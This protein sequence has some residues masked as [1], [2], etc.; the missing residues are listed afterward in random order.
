MSE[1]DICGKEAVYEAAGGPVMRTADSVG[2]SF[3]I[4]R[5]YPQNKV[6]RCKE[7]QYKPDASFGR[8]WRWRILAAAAKK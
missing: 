4:D 8:L 7:H 3:G 6:M 5:P 2:D 1:C